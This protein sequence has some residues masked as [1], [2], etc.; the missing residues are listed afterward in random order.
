[1]FVGE[2][3]E[4]QERR[5]LQTLDPSSAMA[6]MDVEAF[7]RLDDLVKADLE[8]TDSLLS[9]SNR[10]IFDAVSMDLNAIA[11]GIEQGTS[12]LSLLPQPAENAGVQAS[13]FSADFSQGESTK[14]DASKDF[15]PVVQLAEYP[16]LPSANELGIP[17]LR[18][19]LL[20]DVLPVGGTWAVGAAFP[21]KPA[22]FIYG[23]N[24]IGGPNSP[25]ECRGAVLGFFTDDDRFEVTW[26]KAPDIATR[27]R[28]QQWGGIVTP[29]FSTWWNWPLAHKIW[30]IYRQRWV[31][32]YWQEAGLRIIPGLVTVGDPSRT[33]LE[34]AGIPK[35]PPVV[36]FEVRAGFDKGKEAEHERRI[37]LASLNNQLKL[38]EPHAC[39]VYGGHD[40]REW[41][42]KNLIKGPKY[43]HLEQWA[44]IRQKHSDTFNKAANG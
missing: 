33:S 38:I 3:T 32:R 8:R 6:E 28:Q 43:L 12:P 37:L 10:E 42:D 25:P 11:Q 15:E 7:K 4:A 17:D 24:R 5:L 20:S 35:H 36:A 21:S 40:H 14:Y 23:S 16:P 41:I 18:S 39:I 9:E 34:C 29:D 44:T 22:F 27:F 13:G 30:S 26:N 31:G 2:Y 1:V 19:D